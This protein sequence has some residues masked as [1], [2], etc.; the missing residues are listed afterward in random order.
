MN[1]P[2]PP[3][4][5]KA[6]VESLIDQAGKALAD[7]DPAR[8]A[9]LAARALDAAPG[10]SHALYLHGMAA[11]VAGDAATAAARLRASVAAGG[12]TPECHYNLG[13]S[14]HAV[15]DGDGAIQAF[16][17]AI[18][19]APGFAEAYNSLGVSLAAVG[20][21]DDAIAAFQRATAERAGY[22]DA[23][24]NLAT[25]MVGIGQTEAAFGIYRDLL[26]ADP[27]NAR[28][29]FLTGT[30]AL[31]A[32]ALQEAEGYLR[33][34]LLYQ[35]R[36]PGT[37][38]NLGLVLVRMGQVSAAIDA[39]TKATTY[40]PD[41]GEAWF[42]LASAQEAAG[43]F[44]QAAATYE[45]ARP[46]L[47]DSTGIDSN[48]LMTLNY[49][50]ALPA[51]AVYDAHRRWGA[52]YQQGL[53][54]PSASTP[55]GPQPREGRRL[56]IGYVSPDFRLHSVAMFLLP[57]LEQHDR[58]RVEVFAYSNVE[59]SDFITDHVRRHVDHWRPIAGVDPDTVA[60]MIRADGVD[61][62]IDLA[63]HTARNR[64]DVFARR[65][66]PTQMTWLGYPATTGLPAMDIRL[67]DAVSDPPGDADRRHS[68]R[69]LR[70]DGGFLCYHPLGPTPDPLPA[71]LLSRG[72]VSFGSFNALPK[73]NAA[74]AGLWARVLAAVP[75]SRLVLKAAPLADAGMRRRVEG[76]FAAQGIGADRLTLL[77]HSPNHFSH[78]NAY[79]EIDIA[80][81]PI[82]YNGTTTTCEALWMGVPVLTLPGDRHA[83]RVGASL[84]T[85]ADL[86]GWIAA[87]EEDFVAKAVALAV[88]PDHLAT[89]R[90]GLRGLLIASDLC[91]AQRFA[92]RFEAMCH[93]VAESRSQKDWRG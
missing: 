54:P 30:A 4:L 48:I 36:D 88:D 9:A 57:L 3:D 66:A 7:G 71:P 43:I 65:A 75:G 79:G 16:L 31:N 22:L 61:I 14:L 47:A 83:A 53:P 10:H 87:D 35:P 33:Q 13:L 39:F 76:L 11:A 52:G 80:L 1:H 44:E 70:L 89:V 27:G 82:P 56:R 59:K 84:L 19:R 34:S 50:D 26:A 86:T 32:D 81:D 51:D 28:L 67:T 6:T 40:R 23:Y 49:R 90:Q 85:T 21:A 69:L 93:S 68:E 63:G 25:V 73:L 37:W 38:N 12:G 29:I 91:G 24:V 17:S 78:L 58:S 18:L 74:T 15:G 72:Q 45:H 64:L 55:P 42:A 60:A 62:L 2:P 8:T 46:L 5:P 20:R 41:Y 92:K 77:C